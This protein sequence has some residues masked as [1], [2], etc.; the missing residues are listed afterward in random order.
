MIIALEPISYLELFKNT[1]NPYI[2]RV[3]KETKKRCSNPLF[4]FF[5]RS[6]FLFKSLST[7][8]SANVEVEL[9]T[10]PVAKPAISDLVFG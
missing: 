6:C 9:T 10:R 2:H 1:L 3:Q 4:P 7:L 8:N 5:Q